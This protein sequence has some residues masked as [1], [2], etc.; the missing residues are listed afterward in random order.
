M[1]R[2]RPCAKCYSPKVDSGM[3]VQAKATVW[4]SNVEI[5]EW[6]ADFEW[7][8]GEKDRFFARHSQSPIPREDRARFKGL[9]HFPIQTTDSRSS[10]MTM[11]ERGS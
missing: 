4:A 5:S 6:K 7:E 10:S 2:S 11:A 9:D 3:L 1:W 8:R